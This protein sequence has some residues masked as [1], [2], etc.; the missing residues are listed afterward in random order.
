MKIK[1]TLLALVLLI[2]TPVTLVFLVPAPQIMGSECVVLLHG[3]ARGSKS[4]KPMELALTAAEFQTVNVS[5]PSTATSIEQLT[6]TVI[7][8]AL[9]A[10]GNSRV[11]FVTHSMGGILVRAY[12]A[13]NT[14]LNLGR[15]VM[16]APPNKGSEVVDAFSEIAL[17]EWL[18]GP[19][20]LQLGVDSVPTALGPADF[21]LGI[22]AG[23][24]SISPLFSYMI[25]GVDDGKVSVESTRL[26]G[27]TDHIVMPSTH[28]FMMLNPYVIAQTITFLEQAAFDRDL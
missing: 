10:C 14:P 13:E 26:E 11:H 1:L 27:M 9:K 20:G 8:K 24:A 16:L 12:L 21:E 23:N 3:L 15:V 28:T 4:L 6:K 19:A 17:F 7:P 5:Y 18:N 25:D 22:I 2:V